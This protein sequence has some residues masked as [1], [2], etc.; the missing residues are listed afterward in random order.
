MSAPEVKS[1]S[2]EELVLRDVTGP[3]A[4]GG[5]HKRFFDLLF[6]ISVNDFKKTYFGTVLGYFWSLLRPL[7]LF[8]VL[9]FVFTRIFRVGDQA[10]FYPVLLLFNIVLISF[11]QEVTLASVMSVVNQESVVRK[12]HFPRLVIPLATV[13]TGLFNLCTNMLAVLIFLLAFGVAIVWTWL[14]FPVIILALFT[15]TLAISMI[16]SSLYVRYRD[17]GIIWGVVVTA[18]FYATPVLYPLE[19]VPSQY[20]DWILLNPLT[21]IFIEAR[22]W[23]IDP[24]APSAVQA[25]GGFAQLLPSIG[26]YVAICV[27]SVWIFRREVPRIAEEL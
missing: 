9:L 17:V 8:A 27:A 23:I 7:A 12:T 10:E 6:L 21:P 11:F 14:L 20:V 19:I 22:H 18:L 1:D 24:N 26:I 4:V 15:I 2:G 3:S 5:G 16:L 13:L 25:A